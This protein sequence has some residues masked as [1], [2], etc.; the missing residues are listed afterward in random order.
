MKVDLTC[1]EL[2]VLMAPGLAAQEDVIRLTAEVARL[3][4]QIALGNTSP[5]AS[6]S[7]GESERARDRLVDTL[8]HVCHYLSS[9]SKISA[10]KV[11][12]ERTGLGLKEAK[13]I[14]EGTYNGPGVARNF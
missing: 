2:K 4:A 5:A 9:N 14:V 6:A 3:N 10:I 1:E 8:V 12:R 11:V 7:V 13:D